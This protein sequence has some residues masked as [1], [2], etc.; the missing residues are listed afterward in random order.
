MNIY[1]SFDSSLIET[2]EYFNFIQ[3]RPTD[4]KLQSFKVDQ[5]YEKINL[6]FSI[7]DGMIFLL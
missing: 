7:R 4:Q 5:Y 3:I 6:Y 1:I 2:K